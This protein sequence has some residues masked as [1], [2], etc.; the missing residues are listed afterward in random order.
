MLIP[1]IIG[2][3]ANAMRNNYIRY[4]KP[5]EKPLEAKMEVI[6]D[7]NGFKDSSCQWLLDRFGMSNSTGMWSRFISLRMEGD[8]Q[9]AS[10]SIDPDAKEES[11]FLALPEATQAVLRARLKVSVL[12][13]AELN[14]SLFQSDEPNMVPL[15]IRN[16]II[17]MWYRDTKV[18][19]EVSQALSGIP[20]CFR[21]LGSRIFTFLEC[22]G[23]INFGAVPTE[24]TPRIRPALPT[25]YRLRVAVVGAG[26][27]G[28]IAARQL[29]SFG[30][31]V[32]VFEGRERAGGR[33]HTE[34]EKFSAGV[35]MGAMLIL[36]VIQNPTSVLAHQ[37][38]SRMHFMDSRCPLF[39][40]DGTWVSEDADTWAEK[41]FN[42]I[43]DVT[44]R[45]RDR[46]GS[47]EKADRMSLGQAFQ[48]ALEKRARRRKSRAERVSGNGQLALRQLAHNETRRMDDAMDSDYYLDIPPP[49]GRR[50]VDKNVQDTL[51]EPVLSTLVSAGRKREEEE[52][53]RAFKK[54]KSIE[55]ALET[56]MEV[57]IKKDHFYVENDD[58]DDDVFYSQPTLNGKLVSRLLRWH[59]ANLEYACASGIEHVS[60]RHW[61]QD[62]PYAFSGEHVLLKTG[63]MPLVDGLVNGLE[64]NIDFNSKVTCISY[65]EKGEEGPV[66][67]E[68]ENGEGNLG[69]HLFDAVL[70]S[71]PL[72]VLKRRSIRF[73]PSLP[74]AKQEA[75]DRLGFGGLM[76]IAMEFEYQFWIEPDMFGALRE[77]VE[78]RGECYF[79]WNLV[80]STGQPI[81]VA[82]VAEPCVAAMENNKDEDIKNE[83]LGVLRRCY[84]DAP[85]PRAYSISRWSKDEFAG[86]AYTYI[87]VGSS[88]DDYDLIAAPV[89]KKVFFA[90]EHTCRQYPTT[91]A[92]AI[93][94][95]LRE[96]HKILEAYD[97]VEPMAELNAQ[98]VWE[99]HDSRSSNRDNQFIFEVDDSASTELHVPFAR[100]K[101]ESS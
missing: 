80:P 64:D 9:S 73:E 49:S 97:L 71:V 83:A 5:F 43:L 70:V 65:P 28:L 50:K 21:R 89:G 19:L 18:R 69:K 66:Q 86:G 91:C 58:M 12:E 26:M 31:D 68:V 40:T 24:S 3:Y 44:A 93:I 53:G 7:R 8:R 55:Q 94:S 23:V 27:A 17:R 48:R 87:P 25:R 81:L 36:G 96:A 4:I 39:D 59:I 13:H 16:H 32:S 75:I 61:D 67:V 1:V 46:K 10:K 56:Q 2:G 82:V 11:T 95:G 92:S 30:F 74:V 41:E 29:R 52:H 72:G 88:G 42:A 20:S 33:V 100:K 47:E 14:H 99:D 98:C 45:Y 62:D 90:G 6:Y 34:R 63:Y 57:R 38:E 60:L 51:T 77:S 37:T 85:E 54:L 78:K 76:K 15:D 101:S 79:F 22:T 84:P 35:D